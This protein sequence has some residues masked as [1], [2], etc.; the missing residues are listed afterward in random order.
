MSHKIMISSHLWVLLSEGK[1]EDN[2]DRRWI[3]V[4]WEPAQQHYTQDIKSGEEPVPPLALD[5][6]I[7]TGKIPVTC[8]NNSNGTLQHLPKIT[9]W[10]EHQHLKVYILYNVSLLPLRGTLGPDVCLRKQSQRTE[11][12]NQSSSNRWASIWILLSVKRMQHGE[13]V[14]VG[15]CFAAAG[16]GPVQHHSIHQEPNS[17]SEA[18]WGTCETSWKTIQTQVD[19]NPL[20]W[21]QTHQELHQGLAR[22]QEKT[23]SWFHWDT[24]EWLGFFSPCYSNEKKKTNCLQATENKPNKFPSQSWRSR[25]TPVVWAGTRQMSGSSEQHSQAAS[26]HIQLER[27]HS[28]KGSFEICHFGMLR[29][30]T[31]HVSTLRLVEEQWRNITSGAKQAIQAK[32]S[33]PGVR[34][35][36]SLLLSVQA[37]PEHWAKM[38]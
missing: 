21:A 16:P 29:F 31:R 38:C 14:L 19:L 37:Q 36:L 4:A 12:L 32:H 13:G 33:S 26:S 30:V 22:W 9:K 1:N 2:K 18:A 10:L 35:P 27:S 3:L 24:A 28:V 11:L 15:G 25:M 6:F 20:T 23:G 5:S 7:K 34:L 8:I 17:G